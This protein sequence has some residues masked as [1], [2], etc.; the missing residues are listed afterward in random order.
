M[1]LRHVLVTGANKGIGL[2]VV[3]ALLKEFA[4][5]SVFLGSRDTARGEAAR[6]ELVARE[7]L[8]AS[9]VRVVALDVTNDASVAAATEKV[10][11]I[12]GLAALVANAGV[13]GGTPEDLWATNVCGVKRCIDAFKPLLLQARGAAVAVSSG[14]GPMFAA[15]CSPARRAFLRA[16]HTWPELEA[17]AHEYFAAVA[18]GDDAALA[19]AGYPPSAGGN[20]PYGFSKA[21]LVRGRGSCNRHATTHRPPLPP[22]ELLHSWRRCRRAAPDGERLLSWFHRH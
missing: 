14:S 8:W 15:K 4:D 18:S 16:P 12:G 20:S 3:E 5:V 7:P 13:A 19:A 10:S 1:A 17:A 11:A 22:A 6:A 2:A 21:M 9:R